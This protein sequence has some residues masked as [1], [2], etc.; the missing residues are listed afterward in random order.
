MVGIPLN[1]KVPEGY[2]V[3]FS[4]PF[5]VDNWEWQPRL[6]VQGAAGQSPSPVSLVFK[7]SIFSFPNIASH[8]C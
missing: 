6:H 2:A 3:G 1:S 7:F 4:F 5:L 8:G